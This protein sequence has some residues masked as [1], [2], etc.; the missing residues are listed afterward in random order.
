VLEKIT[1]EEHE[2]RQWWG[3]QDVIINICFFSACF[4]NHLDPEIHH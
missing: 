4:A 1:V 2:G 3:L